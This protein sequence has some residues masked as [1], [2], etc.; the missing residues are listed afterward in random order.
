MR[1]PVI[2]SEKF[3]YPVFLVF[4]CFAVNLLTTSILMGG[5]QIK[6]NRDHKISMSTEERKTVFDMLDWKIGCLGLLAATSNVLAM[7]SSLV[8]IKYI[9]VPTQIVIKSAKMIPILIG[10][11]IL[12]RKKYPIYDYV[13]VVAITIWIFMFNYFKP[14]SKMDGENTPFGLAMCFLSLFMDGVTGPIEDKMLALKDLHPY[15]LLFILNFFGFPVIM[16]AALIVEGFTPIRILLDNPQLWGYVVLLSA[17]ASIG[18][19]F[20][21]LCLKLYGSLYTT[22]ITTI[23]KI[24]SSLL[25]IYMFKHKMSVMQWISM[26]G[27]FATLFARQYVKYKFGAKKKG[28]QEASGH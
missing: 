4:T 18:Q 25:S 2:G 16:C 12:F 27:T 11:F 26:S 19:V 1:I 13:A 14:N 15:L 6:M 7:T 28:Q 21:I 8:A 5:M 3:D 22:L 23:R 20:I 9:G 24:V 17:T 10:G